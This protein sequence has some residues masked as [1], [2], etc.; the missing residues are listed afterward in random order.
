MTFWRGVRGRGHR[1]RR[2]TSTRTWGRWRRRL[3]GDT[4]RTGWSRWRWLHPPLHA[5]PPPPPATHINRQSCIGSWVV[6]VLSRW[7]HSRP[8]QSHKLEP[9]TSHL[10][11]LQL[12]YRTLLHLTA[13]QVTRSK[14]HS[15]T[16][17]V[18]SPHSTPHAYPHTHTSLP[19]KPR[20]PA[21]GSLTGGRSP[22]IVMKK[23]KWKKIEYC[24]KSLSRRPRQWRRR[25]PDWLAPCIQ[26][27]GTVGG[28]PRWAAAGTRAHEGFRLNYASLWFIVQSA[29]T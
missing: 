2:C 19:C 21:L 14:A 6:V 1:R 23:K 25:W 13:A 22:F 12:Q 15:P 3:P 28:R 24:I 10:H 4:G 20:I 8:L 29:T 7:P 16:A 26:M 5:P 17:L 11:R 18:T 9:R 27:E